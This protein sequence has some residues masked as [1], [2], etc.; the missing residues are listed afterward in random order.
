MS[1]SYLEKVKSVAICC[2]C[3]TPLI[4]IDSWPN[5]VEL[6]YLSYWGTE[7]TYGSLCKA[8]YGLRVGAVV[9]DDCI[10]EVEKDISIVRFAMK[11]LG[12]RN[13]GIPEYDYIPVHI[14]QPAVTHKIIMN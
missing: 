14:L 3:R 5:F 7:G 9:C 2:H 8:G 1:H 10:K 6:P 11:P 4:E 13:G 12:L